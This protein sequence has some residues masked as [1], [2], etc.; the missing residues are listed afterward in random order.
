MVEQALVSILIPTYN[1]KELVVR[2]I[3]S[4]LAQTYQNIEIVV[5]DNCSPDGTVEFLNS[6]YA[7]NDKVK[8]YGSEENKGPVLNW[9]NCIE[10]CKGVYVKLLFSDD[11]IYPNHIEESLPYLID[12]QDVGFVYSPT[13]IDM[14]VKKMLFYKTYKSSRKVPSAQLDKRF[15]LDSNVPV[16]PGAA[17]FR[18]K[19]L[20][21]GIKLSIP[22]KKG[23]DFQKYGAGIDLNVYF[24]ML[25]KYKY[26]YFVNETRSVFYA[27]TSSFTINNNLDYYYKT[28]RLNY[29]KDRFNFF[30][31]LFFRVLIQMKVTKVLNYF[32]SRTN[33]MDVSSN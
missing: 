5:S 8:I 21:E 6:K 32:F 29:M 7:K 28:V 4:G 10:K 25:R 11:E 19:D 27:S 26:A 17:L 30:E 3:E 20:K 1:R 31:D 14:K 18:R 12:N 24:E 9:V 2:A 22:N 13:I 33:K 15:L 16:S 23:L